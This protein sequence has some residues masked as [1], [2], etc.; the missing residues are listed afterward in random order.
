VKSLAA[1]LLC[2]A[3]CLT[4]AAA[5]LKTHGLG[6]WGKEY[7]RV[8][9]WARANGFQQ[10]WL[11]GKSFELTKGSTR[12]QF[13][14]DSQAMTF[15]GVE[16]R[17]STAAVVKNGNAYIAPLDVNNTLGPLLWP[18]RNK[19]GARVKHICIDPGH[20]GKDTGKRAGREEE[21]KYTLLLAQELGE[22]LRKAG[23]TVSFTRASD[24]FVDLTPR[25]EIANRRRADLFVSLHF[26]A[27]SRSNVRGAET[28]CL[29]PQGA[30]SSNDAAGR[31]NK[32]VVSGNQN[33][34]KNIL[35]AYEIHK[36][37]TRRTGA[38]DRAVKRARFEV[39]REAEMPAVLIEAGFMSNPTEARQ[40][41]S[42]AWRRKIAESIVAGIGSY[43]KLVER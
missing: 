13:A 40:I 20:G 41:F 37:V 32:S 21:K 14:G 26:N 15:N 3:I 12:M 6:L 42:A 5:P 18:T 24:A 35:L 1:L 31:G 23:Y 2:C 36:A 27:F 34:S 39:L 30:A 33:N 43:K 8:E 25:A 17:L 28:Y 22:Q 16:I 10:R 9:E 4:A 11:G 7:Y 38:E 29:T 19:T